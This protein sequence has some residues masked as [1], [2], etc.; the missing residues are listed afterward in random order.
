ME[1]KDLKVGDT[2]WVV[3]YKDRYRALPTVP[4]YEAKVT[5]VG[6]KYLTVAWIVGG[7]SK[8]AR[9]DQFHRDSGVWKDSGYG[10]TFKL[11]LDI[12]A[13]AE[14]QRL[15]QAK[16]RFR[17]PFRG[18]GRDPLGGCTYEEIA[19]AAKLLKIDIGQEK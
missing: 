8:W 5:K 7:D 13:Y 1:L 6:R 18:Y 10:S 14:E 2:A 9:E 16:E 4:M 3:G 15:R 12:N 17:N 11:Y 19:A